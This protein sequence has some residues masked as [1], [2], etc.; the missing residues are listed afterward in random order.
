MELDPLQHIEYDK[1]EFVLKHMSMST[2]TKVLRGNRKEIIFEQI[3][4]P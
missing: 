2:Y 3:I 1:T 4:Q